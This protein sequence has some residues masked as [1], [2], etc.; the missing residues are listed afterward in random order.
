MG[1]KGLNGRSEKCTIKSRCH[2]HIFNFPG[3]VVKAGTDVDYMLIDKEKESRVAVVSDP[4]SYFQ[5]HSLFRHYS[6]SPLFRGGLQEA[7]KKET[8][9]SEEDCSPL[10][11]VI[12]QELPCK[13]IMDDGTCFAVDQKYYKKGVPGKTVIVTSKTSDGTW[14]KGEE[15]VNQFVNTVLAAIKIE[16]NRKDPVKEIFST[17]WFL[18]IDERTICSLPEMEGSAKICVI[19][20]PIDDEKLKAKSGRLQKLIQGLEV[21]IQADK[22]KRKKI[23]SLVVN[24]LGLWE[25]KDDYYRRALYLGLYHGIEK[26][27]KNHDLKTGDSR[28]SPFKAKHGSY[29]IRIAHPDMSEKIKRKRLSDLETDIMAELRCIYL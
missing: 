7:I 27:L 14:P 11:V 16:Q 20:P 3:A 23:T 28:L 4:Q 29:R 2:T 1:K 26:K 6:I 10:F 17:Y 22:Q 18:D 13:T 21:D 12:E 19:S 8:S 9:K 25:I 15:D 24:A 5:K